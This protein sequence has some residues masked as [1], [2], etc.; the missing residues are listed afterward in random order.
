MSLEF[1]DISHRFTTEDVLR[2]VTLSAEAGEITCLLGPSGSGKSTL[3]RL[4]A[5][6]ERLQS[7][8]VHLDGEVLAEPGREPPPE[9]RPVGLVFQEHVLFPHLTVRDNIQ[10]GLRGL[11]SGERR[12]IAEESMASVGLASFA[13]RFPDTLSGGQQ[14]RVALARA[15]AP[16]PR[17]ML[18][19]EPFAN[20]DATLRRALRED[21]RRALRTA[22]VITVL[23]T[24]DPEEALD[25]A[26]RVA[27]LDDGCIVQF[28]TPSE[29]WQEPAS[30]TVAEMFGQAQRLR[31]R[32]DNGVVTTAFGIVSNTSDS[33]DGDVDVIVRPEAIALRK[34][35]AGARVADI[36]F[37]G[38][39]YT[40]I[41]ESDG[42]TLHVSTSDPRDVA[43]GDCVAV[44][45]QGAGPDPGES[46]PGL[47]P[48]GVFV[49]NRK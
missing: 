25:L 33:P 23:V 15:L 5:G 34:A 49:Y 7:G 9:E 10:F 28:G 27:I 6:L 8:S 11:A 47:H 40:V 41:V 31:G 35:A 48:P 3:L 2:D 43:I 32:V 13:D 17:A 39:R 4:A 37:L 24:H 14:Q 42:E 18:L 19:D 22:G 45:F 38:D 26:D 36:R 16:E 1:R 12:R 46:S 29:I 21:A 44:M 20:V 30:R